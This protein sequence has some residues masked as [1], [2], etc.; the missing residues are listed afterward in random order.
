MTEIFE[1]TVSKQF[2]DSVKSIS[3][4]LF[5]TLRISSR[6]NTIAPKEYC[7]SIAEKDF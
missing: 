5:E 7:S 1:E 6:V 3:P 2:A 4:H